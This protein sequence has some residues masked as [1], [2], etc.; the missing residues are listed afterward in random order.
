M[1]GFKGLASSESLVL[2]LSLAYFA[3]LAPFTPGLASL[4]NGANLLATSLPL[5]VVAMGETVVL[6]TGGID[7]SV[8]SIIALSSVTGAAIM[9]SDA[10]L[11]AGN[12]MAVPTGIAA[13]LLVGGLVGL[14]NGVV[15]AQF[16]L[17]PFIATL[18]TMMFFSGFAIWLTQSQNINHLPGAFNAVGGKVWIALLLAAVLAVGAHA[19][20][21][22]SMWGRWL[23]AVGHNARASLIS[24]VPVKGVTIGAYMVSGILAA[25]ASVL[26]TGQAETGSPTMGQKILLDVIGATVIGGT[27]LFGGKGKILWTLFG[28]GFI[29]LIDNSL[30]LLDLSYFSIMMAKGGVILLAALIDSTRNRVLAGV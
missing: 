1:S 15:I 13:M 19:M 18:A 23:Y 20:L 11:L 24:G 10:G 17:P 22:R 6:I 16:R 25:V 29:K 28:V 21:S 26:Y 9:N 30:N 14:F 27:S 8:T 2:L 7:L 5:F 12:A 3:A 4:S